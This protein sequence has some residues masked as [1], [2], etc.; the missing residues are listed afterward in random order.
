MTAMADTPLGRAFRSRWARAWIVAGLLVAWPACTQDRHPD[1]A[2]AKLDFTLK[3][4]HGQDVRLADYKGRP[5]LLNFW[6]TWC[7]PCKYEIPMFVEFAEKYKDQQFT[8]LGITTDDPPDENLRKFAESFKINYPV[9]VA[10]G[11]DEI[12]EAYEAIFEI[13][14]TWLVRADGTIFLK[15][16]GLQTKEWFDRQIQQLLAASA[17]RPE[18]SHD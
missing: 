11:H 2:M 7:A 9:L 6:A 12:Q 16:R 5:L 17:T 13:P 15:H 8:V 10:L 4:M 3:D 14:V 18:P 1:G